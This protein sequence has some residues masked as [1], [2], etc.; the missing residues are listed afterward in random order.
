MVGGPKVTFVFFF[1]LLASPLNSITIDEAGTKKDLMRRVQ[2]GKI[3]VAEDSSET[4]ISTPV[5]KKD[6]HEEPEP[7]ELD[8]DE[9]DA[10]E[11]GSRSG[12]ICIRRCLNKACVGCSRCQRCKS[13]WA[14]YCHTRCEPRGG[15]RR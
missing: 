11:D 2:K 9:E 10:T 7:A 14:N 1:F 5:T 15:K 4:T 6:V 3:K 8:D 13:R 12:S